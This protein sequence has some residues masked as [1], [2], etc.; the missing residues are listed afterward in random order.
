M[1]AAPKHGSAKTYV[2]GQAYDS[3]EDRLILFGGMDVKPVTRLGDTW[4]LAI[5]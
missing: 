1:D 5:N 2:P 3:E 4:E